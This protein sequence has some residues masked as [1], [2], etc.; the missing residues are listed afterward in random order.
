MSVAA[1]RGDRALTRLVTQ[2]FNDLSKPSASPRMPPPPYLTHLF[3]STPVHR[4]AF[5]PFDDTL[6]VGHARG[7][8]TLVV[9]GAGEPNYDSLEADPYESK[10]RRRER[11]V[12]SLLDKVPM[13]LITLDQDVLGRVDREAVKPRGTLGAAA[14]PGAGRK[15]GMAAKDE[16][17]FARKSRAERLQVQGRARLDE[18]IDDLSDGDGDAGG[19]A[20]EEAQRRAERAQKRIEAADNKNRMRG[21]SSGIKKALRKRRRDVIDPQTVRFPGFP[22]PGLS[23]YSLTDFGYGCTGCPEGEARTATGGEQAREGGQGPAGAGGRRRRHRT[24][25]PRPVRVEVSVHSRRYRYIRVW[26][27]GLERRRTV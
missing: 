6:C 21:K 3:P 25:R 17:A 1:R 12:T 10:R 22:A 27:L 15:Q 20:D 9:P 16:V 8:E 7:I 19:D 18:D 14:A 2:V 4:L 11:E 23:Q 13:D 24:E 5:T 26:K